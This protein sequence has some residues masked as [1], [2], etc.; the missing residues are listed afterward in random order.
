[1]IQT[2]RSLREL[3]GSAQANELLQQGGQGYLID[4]Q[5]SEMIDEKAFTELVATLV[6]ALGVTQAQHVLTRSGQLTALYLLQNRIPQFFQALLKLLPRHIALALLLFVISKH[7][8]TFAGSGAFHY[9]LGKVTRLTVTSNIHPVAAVYGFYGGT[10]EQ[11][12]QALIDPK[13]EVQ[14]CAPDSADLSTAD[15][16]TSQWNSLADCIYLIKFH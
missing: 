12:V 15:Q 9:Q 13:A 3:L 2:V 8:W 10:F 1:M 16:I 5:P 7:A 14:S 6:S 4:H 11:L